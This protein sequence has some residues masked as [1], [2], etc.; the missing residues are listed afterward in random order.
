MELIYLWVEEYKN[1]KKQGFN[2][3]PQFE[4]SYNEVT[5]ELTINEKKDYVNIFPKNINMTA[6]VGENGSGKSSI[7]ESLKIYLPESKPFLPL[8]YIKIIKKLEHWYIISNIDTIKNISNL[9]LTPMSPH[10]LINNIHYYKYSLDINE[11]S[12]VDFPSTPFASPAEGIH[13]EDTRL[14]IQYIKNNVQHKKEFGTYFE[15]SECTISINK[16][17]SKNIDTI[18]GDVIFQI[19]NEHNFILYIY[20]FILIIIMSSSLNRNIQEKINEK[21]LQEIIKEFLN[22]NQS[23][24]RYPS[25]SDNLA[26]EQ[27]TVKKLINYIN[28]L[29]QLELK[30]NITERYSTFYINTNFLLKH[31]FILEDLPQLYDID[32]IDKVKQISYNDI[33]SGEKSILRIRFYIESIINKHQGSNN[34]FLIDEPDN[35]MHPNWQKKLIS[36]LTNVFKDSETNFHFIITTHSPFLLSDIP[37]EY[38]IFLEKGKQ[39]YPDINTFG[40]NIHTLLSHGFF[41]KEGLMGEFAEGKINIAIK[42]LNQKTLSDNE[43]EYC[44]NIISIIGEPVLRRQL[45]KML[46]SKRLIKIDDID[47]K[48]KDMEYELSVLKKHQNKATDDELKD[49]AKRKYTKKKKDDE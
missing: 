46:D 38:I 25:I 44:E 34:I 41:M 28:K 29:K 12:H 10:E 5:Q 9:T 42:Y 33:S 1:I 47:K 21:Y 43:I 7:L 31:F 48:I 4:C 45:Q 15:P 26:S 35:D 8:H 30:K 23:F 17:I 19:E 49:R 14:L 39:V 24:G 2:F 20:K 3:S 11:S 16:L 40:A 27:E 32:Y 36:Y 37:Q 22:N 18:L 6:I 13:M